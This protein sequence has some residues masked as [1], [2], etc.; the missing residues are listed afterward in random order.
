V[1]ARRRRATLGALALTALTACSYETGAE[2]EDGARPPARDDEAET[3]DTATDDP[4]VT[5]RDPGVL[6]GECGQVTY[7]PPTAAEAFE[8]E[9]CRPASPE[10]RDVG[11]VLV[12][13]GGG[14]A[15]DHTAMTAWAE[16]YVASG[17]TT[18]A[19]DYRLFTVGLESPVFPQPE[20]NVKAAV[21]YLRG[22]ADTLGL[23]ADR[24]VIH[25][26]SAGARLGAV[27]FTT[28]GDERFAGDELWE[29]IDDEVN[30]FVGY[31]TTYDGTMQYDEQ[32]YGG[33]RDDEDP[34][35]RANWMAADAIVNAAD[36]DA[37]AGPVALFTG[38]LD[39]SELAAQQELLATRVRDAGE[40]ATTHVS[41]GGD[42]GYDA[43]TTGLTSAGLEDA[44]FLAGW[45]DSMFPQD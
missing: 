12:H 13:G 6:G 34:D 20:Q 8:G 33:P 28:A 44:A 17:Y 9:L 36:D 16:Q 19:I 10:A 39:W 42:H 27:A 35:V 32:Y 7:T 5:V 15:G 25:G 4:P 31:Y 45:L 26:A 1:S 11:I 41:S 22:T 2:E 38:E 23:D 37:V 43:S 24:I 3:P 40:E 30:A 29:G 14:I 18:L 21:Q